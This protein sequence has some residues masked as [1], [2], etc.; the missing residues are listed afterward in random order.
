[1]KRIFLILLILALLPGALLARRKKATT[2]ETPVSQLALPALSLSEQRMFDSLYFDALKLE[3]M[4]KPEEALVQMNKAL[5]VNP[6]S[7][8]A[9]YFRSRQKA[10]HRQMEEA[11]SDALLAAQI[12][13]SNVWYGTAAAQLMAQRGEWKRAIDIYESLRRQHPD[14]TDPL[15]HLIEL[16]YRVDSLPKV[17]EVLDKIEQ[18]D[19]INPALMMQKFYMLQDMG[20]VDEGFEELTKVV[21]RYP[22]D[23]QYRIQLGDLQMQNGRLQEAKKTYDE[24][25]KIDPDNAYVWVAQSNYYSVMGDQQAADTLVS[26]ALVHPTLDVETK[27]EILTEYLKSTLRKVAKEKR[28]AKDTTAIIALPGAD[29]LFTK[30]VTMHPTAPEFYDLHA[31][32]LAVVGQDSLAM[33]QEKFAVD[34]RPKEEKYWSRLLAHAAIAKKYKE[35]IA[36]G[37]EAVKM[38]PQVVDIYTTV[39]YAYHQL[40]Q[41]ERVVEW[42]QKGIDNI[43]PT[44]VNMIS[45]LY[46]LLGDTYH[47][48][49]NQAKCY[50]NYEQ[51]LK[52]NERNY[53]VLN[54]YAYFLTMEENGDLLKAER[55]AAQVVQQYPDNATYLDTYAWIFYLQGNYML[56]KFYQQKALENAGETPDETL[57]DHMN[58]IKEK[59]EEQ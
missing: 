19:G 51:A 41:K 22:F 9:L 47:E 45:Q 53:V 49:G 39:G 35:L 10:E 15:Y 31:E 37:K 27:K 36:Y 38:H 52:Y 8:P 17:I 7:A 20:R 13:T 21:N 50:E 33:V 42:Y 16:Y 1:M 28:Q 25:A 23:I 57:V 24:A 5:E 4:G 44:E 55:M 12:D 58:K 59:L 40:G 2:L 29:E 54:N 48:L 11:L 6:N 3:L 46:G 26:A 34:L 18:T 32:Y 14:D 56:A 30:V 43:A